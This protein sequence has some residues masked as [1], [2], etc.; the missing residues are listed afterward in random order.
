MRTLRGC[1]TH[2][3]EPS[4]HRKGQQL[5]FTFPLIVSPTRDFFSSGCAQQAQPI[6]CL[7]LAKTLEILLLLIKLFLQV[8]KSHEGCRFPG[9]GDEAW[10]MGKCRVRPDSVFLSSMPARSPFPVRRLNTKTQ[11]QTLF[12]CRDAGRVAAGGTAGLGAG[13]G[14]LRMLWGGGGGARPSVEAGLATAP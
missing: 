7:D 10:S 3:V 13:E 4:W 2:R 9:S 1:F 8:L 14:R 5:F 12:R 6:F 11:A